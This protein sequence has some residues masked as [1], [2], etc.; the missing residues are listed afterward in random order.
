MFFSRPFCI[1]GATSLG[2]PISQLG[3]LLL[4]F[5]CMGASCGFERSLLPRMAV[6]IFNETKASTRLHFVATFGLAKALANAMS[7]SLADTL[8]R[9]PVLILGCL[10][11]LP[12]MPYVIVANSWSG[13]TLMNVLFGLSQGL[14]GS[15]LFFLLI[16]L[17]GPRRRGIAVGMGESTIYVSTAIV[18]VL[19]GRLASVYGFRPVPFYVATSISVLGLLSTIPLQ[20]T[21]DQVRAEQT[22]SERI[23][24]KK[25]A[26]LLS[27][28]PRKLDEERIDTPNCTDR[29]RLD[30]TNCGIGET[31]G[32]V[33]ESYVSP[34][35]MSTHTLDTTDKEAVKENDGDM[36]T[37]PMTAFSFATS[38]YVSTSRR[39]QRT[40]SGPLRSVKMLKSPET[41]LSS[42]L[43]KN[44][45]Y[46][47]LC[48]G[49]M[50]LNFK[51]GFCWGSF[52]VFFK[53]EHGLSDVRTD[54]LI[55]IYPLC[56]GSAQ[57]FTGA[58]SDRFGRKSFL[59]A[60]V[61]CCAVSMVIYVLP[62]YCWGVA[63]G[64]K[65]FHVWVAADVL[66]GFG[67]ALAYP[68]LQAGAADE[69]DPAYRGLA[70][71]FYRFSR[72]MGYVLGAIVCGPLTDAIGYEDTFL[73]NGTVLCLA[74]ILLLVFYSDDQSEQTFEFST[75]TDATFKPSPFTA[76]KSRILT[77][78]I[79][80]SW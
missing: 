72:D 58:L 79:S 78:G 5:A 23:N 35:R 71:G 26:R 41:S 74:F 21:L 64:S 49:G 20:D 24:R 63:A 43:L 37:Q 67:T 44:R 17:M 39:D 80:D 42:L 61:G 48:F 51:D 55:A 52:P 7:G 6:Q 14:L 40:S 73:V 57:A 69:V 15:S 32:S 4:G 10:V 56:W 54:W 3:L 68:A 60:G 28:Q 22:E 50:S 76:G 70:L 34:W 9:K 2:F 66:L 75:A 53:H 13:V 11:G 12:V 65:H 33:D 62:S 27:T 30:T 8:G 29:S 1:D 77:A 46:V 59:V 19:A 38:C 36:E 18:N 16:D 31:Y 47:A 45:S 25:Y